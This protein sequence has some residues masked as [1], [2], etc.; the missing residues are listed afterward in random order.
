MFSAG[1]ATTLDALG[2]ALG[3]AR[4]VALV[5]LVNLVLVPMIGWATAATLSLATSGY[6]ALVLVCSSPGGPFGAKLAMTQRGDVVTGAALQV[7][8]AAVG[9]VT[10]PITAN[11]ILSAADLGGG[12][13]L[14]VADLVKTVMVLQLVPFGVG[15]AIRRWAPETA[16]EWRPLAIKTSSLTF[17]AVLSGALLGSW[18]EIVS[19]IGSATILAAAIVT[20]LAGA[21]G[22]LLTTGSRTTRTTVGLLAPM[23]NS[24]PVFAAIAIG[25]KGDP[26][27][28]G[29]TTGIILTQ[30]VLS[31]LFASYLAKG[32]P[33][34][35]ESPVTAGAGHSPARQDG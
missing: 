27:I 3:N 29:A 19:L 34:P 17:L 25:F 18:Q 35:K 28:L 6:V 21:V 24:G 2:A 31:T 7:L 20:V 10:F 11:W 15:L 26:A 8:L 14:P 1:L 5:L 30:T 4:L 22:V 23:R 32:R 12:L 9:S 33:A 16:I 13:S